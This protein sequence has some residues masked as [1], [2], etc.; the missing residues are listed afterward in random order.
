MSQSLDPQT[1]IDQLI[2]VNQE[3]KRNFYTAA[4]QLENRAT[5]L[6]LKAYAQER[7]RFIHELEQS[8]PH[9]E[10]A[11]VENTPAPAGGFF[12]R[13]WLALKAA[14]VIRR[15]RRH[16]LLLAELQQM[17]T[18]TIDA[19]AKVATFGLPAALHT[20]VERQY[21]RIRSVHRWVALMSQQQERQ[22]A[23][24]LFNQ[25]AEAEQAIGR[26]AQ[27]GIP[28]SELAIVPVDDIAVY[29][30]EQQARPRATREAIVTGGL[31][32]LLAGGALGLIYGSFHRTIFPD[33]TGF[34]TSDPTGIMWEVA[35]YG[36]IIGF[37]FALIFSTLIAVSAA[38][39]DIHLSEESFRKGDTLVAVST[40]VAN[41][42]EVERIIGLKHEHE[43]AP[44]TA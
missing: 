27:M 29:A 13:G 8:R 9:P 36:A 19:Y 39:I 38:E 26:L 40:N 1:V 14:L 30:N 33:I 15:Q 24:R 41:L 37:I 12:Q 23:V 20:L 31:L 25:W 32:G 11:V 35:L 3:S 10:A 2:Q 6:L 28:R 42:R 34:L 17:E 18:N 22:V 16:R 44:M 43:I 7:V 21:E 5:K 4:A